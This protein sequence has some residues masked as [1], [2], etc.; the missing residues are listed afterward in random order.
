MNLWI[1]SWY[2]LRNKALNTTLNTI[3]LALG[4]GI[5]VFLLLVQKQLS[6]KF[7][8][9]IKGIKMV[10]GAKGS[11]LQLILSNVYHIDVPTGNIPLTDANQISRNRFFV[12][13]SIPLALGDSY[14]GFRIV[15]TEPSY[16]KHYQ[17]RLQKGRIWQKTMEVTIGAEV[18]ELAKLKVGSTFLGAHGLVSAE[19]AIMM[20]EEKAYKVVGIFA[21]SNTVLD[22]L[23]LCNIESVWA[24]HE[25]HTSEVPAA[26]STTQTDHHESHQ[27]ADST[28]IAS[29]GDEN[30]EIT[31]LLITEYANPLAAINLPRTVNAIGRLQAASPALEITRLFAL[32]GIGEQALQ[33]FALIIIVIAM[34]SVFIALY[35]ALKERQYDLA[36]MRTLGASKFKLFSQIILEGIILAALGAMLGLLLGHAT[37]YLISGMEGIS[38]KI[39]LQAWIF[40]P[41]E[42][43][44]LAA[45]FTVGLLAAII[46]AFQI[47]RIDISKV[48]SK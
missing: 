1:I 45:I 43:W 18:A 40:L 9:D 27:E 30:K 7:Q 23:I 33:A 42:L 31:A 20:H 17:M 37:V 12:K 38:D 11:P 10:V 3:L 21:P 14:Q 26:D 32:I 34:L 47:Y 39:K 13:G 15:G 22:R 6:D 41:E 46:P 44:V 28:Q 5:I 48:L 4:V 36:I 16:P 24:V 35:N 8:N 29:E 25:E 19:D 2:Y